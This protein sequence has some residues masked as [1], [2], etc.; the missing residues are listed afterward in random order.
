MKNYIVSVDLGGTKICAGIVTTDGKIKSD[1]IKLPTESEKPSKIILENIVRAISSA[2]KSAGVSNNKILG[3]GIGSPGPLDIKKGII[4]T[5]RNLPSLHGF[6]LKKAIEKEFKLPVYLNN[7][8][9]VYVLGESFFGAGAKYNIVFGVTLGTGLGSG[10]VINKKIYNGATGTATE[11]WGF[12]YKEGIMEDYVSGRGLK[13]MY[14]DRTGKELEPVMIADSA[15]RGD[16]EAKSSWE[17]F[18]RH[19]GMALIYV[20]DVLDP[21]VIV[22]GGSLSNQY[23]LF[24]EE[25]ERTVRGKI[26]SMPRAHLKIIKTKLKE[27]AALLGAAGLVLENE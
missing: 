7:D 4:L 24:S 20:I 21:D 8:A 10:L 14:K 5:P 15:R 27:K 9:N 17:E 25:L 1:I 12:P 11:I 22:I 16:S 3:I 18:G 2:I 6:N 23:D 19:L 13:R 26:Y